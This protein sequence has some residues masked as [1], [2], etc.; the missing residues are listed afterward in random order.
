MVRRIAFP[1]R[2]C[3]VC[4]SLAFCLCMDDSW[5]WKCNRADLFVG[6]KKAL[7]PA[8]M[9]LVTRNLEI[10][11]GQQTARESIGKNRKGRI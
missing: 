5:D 3:F 11:E 7:P 10:G 8:D 1:G 9:V 6:C 4:L 2:C